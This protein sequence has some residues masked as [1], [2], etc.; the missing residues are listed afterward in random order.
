MSGAS[1]LRPEEAND[2]M[3]EMSR[4]LN[5][6][7]SVNETPKTTLGILGRK[8]K[9][10]YWNSLLRYFLDPKDPHGIETDLLNEVLNRI[11]EKEFYFGELELEDVR[12]I[13]EASAER[14]RPDVVVYSEGEWMVLF[15]LK[16]ESPEGVNQTERYAD[17]DEVDGVELSEL[18]EG[19]FYVFLSKQD[20]SDSTSEEFVDMSWQEVVDSIDDVLVDA[21]GS[22]TAKATA[23]LNDFRDSIESVIRMDDT[24]NQRVQEEKA[25]LYA[26]YQSDIEELENGLD[27]TRK[28]EMN[29]WHNRL[30]EEFE[31]EGWTEEWNCRKSK[32]G[33]IYRDDWWLD[34]NGKPTENWDDLCFA[35]HF[36][37]L[38]WKDKYETF[39]EG[40][41]RFRLMTPSEADNGYRSE[42][43][44][45]FNNEYRSEVKEIIQGL[46]SSIEYNKTRIK[47][48]TQYRYS[49]DATKGTEEFY[50][51]LRTAVEQHLEL[52]DVITE[53]HRDAVERVTDGEV[54][55]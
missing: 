13:S 20:S 36:Q 52:E 28:R 11:P 22:Y 9:E 8:N 7:P 51:T 25:K 23:Q 10:N 35:V 55:L 15:E 1:T 16:V 54:K 24:E 40:E 17:A 21:R 26:E 42:F 45:L 29:K 3:A 37:A 43:Q 46:N 32:R 48:R 50:R 27:M 2:R 4:R 49:F 34:E 41:F 19:C 30:I 39:S 6:L 38:F 31:P 14:G 33:Q 47:T 53:A 12:V 44:R 18:E 5:S